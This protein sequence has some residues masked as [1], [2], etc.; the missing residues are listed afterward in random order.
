ME[1]AMPLVVDLARSVHRAV[2]VASLVFTI[3]ITPAAI[4]VGKATFFQPNAK[5]AD[6]AA[7]INETFLLFAALAALAAIFNQSRD[8][9]SRLAWGWLL[10]IATLCLGL[11][12]L[13]FLLSLSLLLFYGSEVDPEHAILSKQGLG[14]A[15]SAG[16][17]I[18]SLVIFVLGCFSSMFGLLCLFAGL[19]ARASTLQEEWRHAVEK[20]QDAGLPGQPK[21]AAERDHAEEQDAK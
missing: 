2:L 15:L 11:G 19:L 1:R 10:E 18:A 12:A 6:R 9:Q 17:R 4:A 13:W 16:F 7:T 20:L 14:S 3:A 5:A 8:A 21:S